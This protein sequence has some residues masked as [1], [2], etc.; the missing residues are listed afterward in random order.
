[1]VLVQ[2]TI[3]KIYLY[4][5]WEWWQPGENTILYMP[6]NSE[7]TYLDEVWRSTSNNW[8]VFWEYAWVDCWFFNRNYITITDLAPTKTTTF[9]WRQYDISWES[10]PN[11][12]SNWTQSGFA[13]H[14]KMGITSNDN[15][16]LE[17]ASN[18][19]E[20]ES[21]PVSGLLWSWHN[22]VFVNDQNAMTFAVYIDWTLWKSWTTTAPYDLTARQWTRYIWRDCYSWTSQSTNRR[23]YSYMSNWIIETK[24]RTADE[25]SNY[26]DSTKSLYW[27]S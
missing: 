20:V 18:S 10:Y 23:T 27:I 21:H 24:A 25:V 22:I 3:K 5:E 7:T 8:V 16:G 9:N 4:K 2:K 26:Y 15:V 17:C 11:A 14:F 6:L 12:M 13:A 19:T 1:M